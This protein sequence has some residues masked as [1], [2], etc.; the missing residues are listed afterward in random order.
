M[1]FC[2]HRIQ[3]SI[4]CSSCA[5]VVTSVVLHY[6][7]NRQR[8][9]RACIDRH[10]RLCQLLPTNLSIRLFAVI[11]DQRRCNRRLFARIDDERVWVVDN[12]LLDAPCDTAHSVLCQRF[13]TL[14][15]A[16]CGDAPIDTF[17]GSSIRLQL[18]RLN[19]LAVLG[20]VCGFCPDDRLFITSGDHIKARSCG[21]RTVVARHQ[22]A[23]LNL[24]PKPLGKLVCFHAVDVNAES[25]AAFNERRVIFAQTCR[26]NLDE[27]IK[28]FSAS[29]FDRAVIFTKRAPCLDLRDIFQHNDSRTNH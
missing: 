28:C 2:C 5:V 18:A 22:F 20:S 8:I 1:I 24:V 10:K 7:S 26:K 17:C 11:L 23:I 16:L 3:R 27:P 29:L 13:V 21:G 19:I 9:S 15:N 12:K 25:V 14:K 4:C 6:I